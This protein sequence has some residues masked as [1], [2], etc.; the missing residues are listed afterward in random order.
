MW[1]IFVVICNGII[2]FG[3]FYLLCFIFLFT[4][5]HISFILLSDLSVFILFHKDFIFHQ[6]GI[7]HTFIE[8]DLC[9]GNPFDIFWGG[10]THLI[11]GFPDLLVAKFQKCHLNGQSCNALGE[12]TM[13][14]SSIIEQTKKGYWVVF[15]GFSQF[16]F[17]FFSFF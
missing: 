12:S 13:S 5:F 3:F 1:V 16:L 7:F 14:T 4:L 10:K 17:N 8:S 15:P 9:E 11:G 6:V 2:L